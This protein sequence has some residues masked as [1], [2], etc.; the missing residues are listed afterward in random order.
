MIKQTI[1]LLTKAIKARRAYMQKWR[2]AHRAEYREYDAAYK[3]TARAEN[4]PSAERIRAAKRS[5]S[6][7]A[8]TNNARATPEQKAKARAYVREYRKRPLAKYKEAA[9]GALGYAVAT[10]KIIRPDTCSLCHANPE[11]SRSGRSLIRADH[12]HGYAPAHHLYIQWICARC[13]GKTERERR[14]AS[15]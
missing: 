4:K 14:A 12:W 15:A 10:G 2:D 11:R 1:P 3:R 6:Y 9:R 13:D 5:Q 8:K 7:R